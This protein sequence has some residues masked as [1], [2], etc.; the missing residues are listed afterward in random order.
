MCVAHLAW[1]ARVWLGVRHTSR[2]VLDVCQAC[3]SHAPSVVT[4]RAAAERVVC[5]CVCASQV[6]SAED[7]KDR[8]NLLF[9]M[10]CSRLPQ[11]A[12]GLHPYLVKVPCLWLASSVPL[13]IGGVTRMNRC[14]RLTA[15][16]T[17]ST[18][19]RPSIR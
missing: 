2:L 17:C 6:M 15:R 9:D 19:L 13:V 18:P 16:R 7:T 3:R 1:D 14:L 4:A 5:L 11:A 10:V 12:S 8:V